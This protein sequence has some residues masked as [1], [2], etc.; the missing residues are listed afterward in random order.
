[1]KKIKFS[2]MSLAAITAVVTAFAAKPPVMCDNQTQY[3]RTGSTYKEAGILSLDYDCDWNEVEACTYV[4]VGPNAYAPCKS[5]TF[6]L[7]GARKG[8]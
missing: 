1:M 4:L 2:L 3:Y 8:K 7:Y 6:F 5:G